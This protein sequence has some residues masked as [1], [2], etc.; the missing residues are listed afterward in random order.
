MGKRVTKCPHCGHDKWT[1]TALVSL[2][3]NAEGEFQITEDE[4][5]EI[6]VP[7]GNP[8]SCAECGHQIEAARLPFRRLVSPIGG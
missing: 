7:P 6:E 3:V 5:G 4:A 2:E 1:V 8:W